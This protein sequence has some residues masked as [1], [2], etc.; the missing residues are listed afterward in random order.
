MAALCVAILSSATPALAAG[1]RQRIDEAVG[2]RAV[3]VSVRLDGALLY[4]RSDRAKRVPASNE[5]LLMSLALLDRVA[6][7]TR[8]PSLAA[9][10][11]GKLSDGVV[12]GNLWLIG[13]GDPTVTDGGRYARSLYIDPTGLGKL[14]R[15]IKAAGVK[16]IAGRVM[17]STGYFAHDWYAEGWKPD[18]PSEEVPIPTA[19][20]FDGNRSGDLHYADP[21]RRAAQALTNRLRKI[22]VRVADPPAQG[23]APRGLRTVAQVESTKLKSLLTHTN[24]QSSNFFAEVLGKRLGVEA[25]GTPGTIAKAA[26]AIRAFAARHGV[27]L[28]AYDSSG[29]SYSNRVSPR[30]I[31]KLLAV[32]EDEAWGSALR[33]TLPKGDQGTLEHRLGNVRLRAKTGSLERISALS[34]W[35]WLKRVKTWAPFSI[36]SRGMEKPEAAGIED[37]IVKILSAAAR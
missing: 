15:R 5:K 20:T 35:V 30:G 34:G 31:A 18:F 1:W 25:Y 9:I 37:R 14:A 28:R 23:A 10:P 17:G 16:R 13:R 32:A 21:E 26:R 11:A 27:K 24:R 19:L 2:R 7:E 3:G 22:G 33:M 8:I 29:L 4:S 36:M 6:P 12:N